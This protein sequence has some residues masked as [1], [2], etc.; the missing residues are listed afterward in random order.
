MGP[1]TDGRRSASSTGRRFRGVRCERESQGRDTMRRVLWGAAASSSTWSSLRRV[2]AQWATRSSA[3]PAGCAG[4]VPEARGGASAGGGDEQ[5]EL[6]SALASPR[7]PGA[8]RHEVDEARAATNCGGS[9]SR[10]GAE[11]GPGR[12][13][14][15]G[16]E[17]LPTEA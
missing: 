3:H 6:Q 7:R 17:D 5:R 15:E 14:G 11:Q 1:T 9:S 8:K 2:G 10:R 16:G 13:L 4:L 12:R